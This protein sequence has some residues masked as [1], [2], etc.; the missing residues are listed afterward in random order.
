MISS[1]TIV[2][3]VAR[4][5][6]VIPIAI[7]REQI[8]EVMGPAF[9]DLFAA[10]GEQGVAPAGPAF[11]H[12]LRNDPGVFDFELGVPIDAPFASTGRVTPGEL[13]AARVAQTVYTGGYEGLGAAWG[14]LDR[15]LK[16][17]G[18]ETAGAFWEIYEAG[19]ETGVDPSQY[20]TRL[21]FV[22]AS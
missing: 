14:E 5:A 6:A 3:T 17:E 19:P 15:W 22:L 21:S 11:S 1:P 16:D 10:L 4:R 20:R 13:P 2:Q 9:N 12:H 18:L 7:P 8:R